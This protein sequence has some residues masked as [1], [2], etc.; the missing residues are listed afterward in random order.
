MNMLKGIEILSKTP[1]MEANDK[2][3]L[4]WA[5]LAALTLI[6]FII[7]GSI[8]EGTDGALIWG[9]VSLLVIIVELII[10]GVVETNTMH[11]TGKYTYK[12]TI[13]KT[14]SML[15]FNQKYEIISQNGS[16]FEIKDKEKDGE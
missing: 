8:L 4:I 13:D 12:V 3:F 11:E 5:I 15:E 1:I 16:I 9:F 14:V 6:V 2:V 10:C 7:I